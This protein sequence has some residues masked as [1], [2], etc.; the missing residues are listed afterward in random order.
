[1]ACESQNLRV[2]A[3]DIS[4]GALAVA[5]QNAAR[6]ACLDRLEFVEGDGLTPVMERA[7]GFDLI[8]SNP[9]YV[10]R[11]DPSVDWAVSRYEPE[12]AVFAGASGLEM[13]QKLLRDSGDLL[14]PGGWLVV[15]LG[16]DVLDDVAALARELGWRLVELVTD[17]AGVNRCAVLQRA[18]EA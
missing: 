15:E 1:L 13:Y 4:R 18:L 2:T 8:V 11:D 14:R 7:G 3:T 12:E 6:H 9:P 5:Q 17:L 10:R 16:F